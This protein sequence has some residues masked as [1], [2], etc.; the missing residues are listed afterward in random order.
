MALKLINLAMEL[1]DSSV[2]SAPSSIITGNR[3]LK[4]WFLGWWISFK[5]DRSLKLIKDY[6]G[7]AVRHKEEFV[8]LFHIDTENVHEHFDRLPG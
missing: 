4:M 1:V 2:S 7:I 6:F 3:I 8:C 5:I